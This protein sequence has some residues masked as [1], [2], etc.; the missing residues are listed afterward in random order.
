MGIRKVFSN[1]NQIVNGTLVRLQN[2][3]LK[4]KDIL[5]AHTFAAVKHWLVPF[6]NPQCDI[7]LKK[8]VFFPTDPGVSLCAQGGWSY[9]L[10][11][12]FLCHRAVLWE[13]SCLVYWSL[14]HLSL[15]DVHALRDSF[16]VP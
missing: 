12:Y 11:T 15:H 5:G 1:V 6:V 13:A 8:I 16:C 14:S 2:P 3:C 10:S 9:F 4:S 7:R